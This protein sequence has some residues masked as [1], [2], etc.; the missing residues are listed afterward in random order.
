M[1]AAELIAILRTMPPD[2]RV[3]TDG[4]E[5]GQCDVREVLLVPM[6]LDRWPRGVCYGPY[7]VSDEYHEAQGDETVVWLPRNDGSEE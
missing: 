4:Y 3:V 6:E 1:T 5:A 2:A 7:Q